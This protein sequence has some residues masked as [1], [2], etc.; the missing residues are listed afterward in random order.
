M[1]IVCLILAL[2]CTVTCRASEEEAAAKAI[3]SALYKQFKIE[4]NVN[5]L[6]Q[7]RVPPE[8]KQAASKVI[9]TIDIVVKKRV[10]LTWSF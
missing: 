8:L 1:K 9:M 4:D 2:L 3:G 7:E 5:L 10:E 6:I